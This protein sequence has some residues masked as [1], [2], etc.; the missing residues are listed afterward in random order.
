MKLLRDQVPFLRKGENRK[1]LDSLMLLKFVKFAG[2]RWTKSRGEPVVRAAEGGQMRTIF[3]GVILAVLCS[4]LASCSTT[5]LESQTKAQNPRQARIHFLRDSHLAAMGD[6]A[7]EIQVNGEKVGTLANNSQFFIDRDPGTYKISVQGALSIGGSSTEVTLR[8][9]GVAYVEIAP[10]AAFIL[11]S[12]VGGAVGGVI[13]TSGQPSS[14]S[15]RFGITAL[16]EKAGR[17]LLQ[18]IKP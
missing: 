13:A 7:P 6:I 18:R 12:A 14:G 11:G 15:G 10:R 4:V 17:E 9:G 2:P 5:S 3:A 16:D 1:T 8:P